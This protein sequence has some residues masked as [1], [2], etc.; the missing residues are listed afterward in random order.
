METAQWSVNLILGAIQDWWLPWWPSLWFALIKADSNLLFMTL[1]HVSF[2]S[3]Y[4]FLCVSLPSFKTVNALRIDS[5]LSFL[6]KC[7]ELSTQQLFND[8]FFNGKMLWFFKFWIWSLNSIATLVSKGVGK[9]TVDLISFFLRRAESALSWV[10][11]SG[12]GLSH[13]IEASC[14]LCP[15]PT[16][17]TSLSPAC[18]FPGPGL[19]RKWLPFP[20]GCC[21][22]PV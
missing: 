22:S 7:L 16:D 13:L 20:P 2:F 11:S 1:N 10:G 3:P 12:V 19:R 14:H 8:F 9:P 18:R 21:L 15:G 5:A 4:N 17:N 6:S